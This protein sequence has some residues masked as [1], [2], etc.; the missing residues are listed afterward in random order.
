MRAVGERGFV[1]LEELS[2]GFCGGSHD[3]RDGAQRKLDDG[4]I[5]GGEVAKSL[6]R[7]GSQKVEVSYDG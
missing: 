1:S 7:D 3:A 5:A 2:G 6:V 4:S